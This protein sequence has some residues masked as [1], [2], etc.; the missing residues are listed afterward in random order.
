MLV[1]ALLPGNIATGD[2]RSGGFSL[3]GRLEGSS[4]FKSLG[5]S[6]LDFLD[7]FP[8]VYCGKG[9]VSNVNKNNLYRVSEFLFLY[10]NSL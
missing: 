1:F 7:I 4:R 9:P 3:G 5:C 2:G 10:L 8:C 6:I